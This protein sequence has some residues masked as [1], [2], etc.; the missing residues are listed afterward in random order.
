MHLLRIKVKSHSPHGT[1]T[2]SDQSEAVTTT[3]TSSRKLSVPGREQR[4]NGLVWQLLPF[5]NTLDVISGI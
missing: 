2:L 3:G 4:Y 1:T 5:I